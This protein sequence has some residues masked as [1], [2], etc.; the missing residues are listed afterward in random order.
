MAA[1]LCGLGGLADD[2]YLVLVINRLNQIA[3]YNAN[4][5]NRWNYRQQLG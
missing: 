1:E 5:R 4:D 2:K 3:A